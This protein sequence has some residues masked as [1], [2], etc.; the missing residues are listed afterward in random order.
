VTVLVTGAGGSI[1]SAIVEMVREGGEDVLAQDLRAENLPSQVAGLTSSAGDLRDD[2]YLGTLAELCSELGV[3]R[4]IAAHGVEGAAPLRD[5]DP[6]RTRFVVAVN[7]T[8]VAR[9]LDR[10]LPGLR[11]HRGV[12]VVVSSQAGVQAEPN[13][14]AYC[15]AKF[16]LVGWAQ[17]LAPSLAR[18]GVRLRVLCPGCTETEL[19]FNAFDRF[20][21]AEGVTRAEALRRR[22][23]TVPV[24]RL[25]SAR[26]TAAA[27]VYLADRG[28]RP[29]IIGATGGEVQI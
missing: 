5:L 20:A 23:E 7:A 2:E 8:T 17:A 19:L 22:V 6:D 11:R 28:A 25:A 18:E 29:T 9:L 24:G 14:A 26:E 27:A 13:L 4:V 16:A 12:F 3:D 15:A 1:G 10:L 21:A